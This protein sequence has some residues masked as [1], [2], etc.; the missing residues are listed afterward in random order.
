MIGFN[1]KNEN[2]FTLIEVMVALLIFAFA[3]TSLTA[4]FQS[5]TNASIRAEQ[6]TQANMVAQYQIESVILSGKNKEEDFETPIKLSM[7]DKQWTITQSLTAHNELE[8]TKEKQSIELTEIDDNEI[9]SDSFDS[10]GPQDDI[11]DIE[12]PD[13]YLIYT[14]EVTPEDMRGYM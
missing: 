10:T 5:S 8:E 14:V 2:G 3:A 12:I 4:G 11:K 13:S 7:F 6:N 1:Q 9:Y